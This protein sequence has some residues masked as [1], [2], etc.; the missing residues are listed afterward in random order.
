MQ[1]HWSCIPQ[2]L[3]LQPAMS[4]PRTCRSRQSIEL[5][6]QD[7]QN[8]YAKLL[9]EHASLWSNSNL[10]TGSL[11]TRGPHS[12]TREFRDDLQELIE[13]AIDE[14]Y[15]PERG[16]QHV[17]KGCWFCRKHFGTVEQVK[18][19]ITDDMS[20]PLPEKLSVETR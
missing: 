12:E 15:I 14:I 20:P 17:I 3:F 5:E 7:L 13:V 8:A 2:F 1:K 9:Y 18:V 10:V 19:H 6:L 16:T 11:S 4:D